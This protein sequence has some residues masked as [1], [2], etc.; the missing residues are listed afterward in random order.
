MSLHEELIWSDDNQLKTTQ[1]VYGDSPASLTLAKDLLND[2]CQKYGG[3]NWN[4]SVGGGV[5]FVREMSFPKNWG[6][7]HRLCET[8][9]SSSNLKTTVVRSA[10][11][12]LERASLERRR[13]KDE[14][15]KPYRVEGV[16]EKDQPCLIT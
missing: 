11:E 14:L 9:F 13:R 1:F 8:D 7:N 5:V 16:P 10:G 2:I 15:T 12:W 4:V 3:Y 6:M